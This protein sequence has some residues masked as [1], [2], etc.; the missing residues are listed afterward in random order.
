MWAKVLVPLGL[1]VGEMTVGLV[2]VMHCPWL[3]HRAAHMLELSVSHQFA[4]QGTCS[5]A[6]PL[7]GTSS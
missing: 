1:F 7:S 4:W 3:C 2:L 5:F 6:R